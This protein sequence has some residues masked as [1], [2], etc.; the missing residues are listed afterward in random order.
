MMLVKFSD[1]QVGDQFKFTPAYGNGRDDIAINTVY[2]VVA[3]KDKGLPNRARLSDDSPCVP[4]S[5]SVEV[6]K[7]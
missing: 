4:V 1:L 5:S 2:K 7:L 6:I 3:P